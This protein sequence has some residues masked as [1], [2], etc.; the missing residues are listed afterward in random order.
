[1][2]VASTF[3][4]TI[5]HAADEMIGSVFWIPLVVSAFS[6]MGEGHSLV[7]PWSLILSAWAARI[8]Y[9]VICL[10]VLQ[11]LPAQHFFG[12]KVISTYHPEVG[13][14]LNQAALRVLF[15]QFKYLLGPSIYFMA[16]FHR[17]RQHL[18]DIL[19]ET[20]VV[21]IQERAL[22]PKNRY[23]LAS[24]LVFF[25]LLTSIGEAAAALAEDRINSKGVTLEIPK[26]DIHI[27]ASRP[28]FS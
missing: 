8:A 3:R 19:A 4:R 22:P 20:R 18:G 14:G 13:L 21:Q 17:D 28:G 9:E 25:S 11:A 1:M 5:A 23:V 24:V 26:L 6:Q 10:Y 16:L 2:N 27:D 15:A 7:L 12:L